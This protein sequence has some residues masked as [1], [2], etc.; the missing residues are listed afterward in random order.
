MVCA[1][2]GSLAGSSVFAE[3]AS[4]VFSLLTERTGWRRTR[5]TAIHCLGTNSDGTPK[6][7][8]RLAANTKLQPYDWSVAYESP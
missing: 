2:G 3:R 6:H 7:P 4:S 8:V 1:W 5:P